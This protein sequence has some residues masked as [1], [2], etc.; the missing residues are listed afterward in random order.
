MLYNIVVVIYCN[1]FKAVIVMRELFV[2]KV[3]DLI[4]EFLDNNQKTKLKEILTET[5]LNYHIE[6]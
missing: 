5:C 2:N 3:I 1:I 6:Y 4:K